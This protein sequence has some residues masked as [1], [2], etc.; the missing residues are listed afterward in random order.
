MVLNVIT[1]I[2][3]KKM[4]LMGNAQSKHMWTI[5]LR[6]KQANSNMKILASQKLYFSQMSE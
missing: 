6:T 2:F 1:V 4:L 3:L 5:V